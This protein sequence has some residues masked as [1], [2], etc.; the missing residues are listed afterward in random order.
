MGLL[1]WDRSAET[2]DT[3]GSSV[4]PDTTVEDVVTAGDT[5]GGVVLEDGDALSLQ[6]LITFE[7]VDDD[8]DIVI[9]SVG[10]KVREGRAP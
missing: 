1:M 10:V 2:R 6:G 7:A 8:A 5:V 4:T 9:R 3:I